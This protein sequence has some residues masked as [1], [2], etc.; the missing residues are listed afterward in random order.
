[1]VV[2]II[3]IGTAV[4]VPRITV[5]VARNKISEAAAL[6]QR[7]L[8]RSFS[9]AARLRKSVTLTA[10]NASA[11]YQV[12]DALAGTVRLSRNLQQ[13]GTL[14]VETMTFS[15][16]V[17]TFLPN[18]IASS[19]ITVTL[20]SHGATRVVTMTRVGLIRRSQ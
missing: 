2:V 13:V 19:P 15:P 4:A 6:V 20:T 9:T 10:D 14:G 7:D 16:T 8:E 11:T 3:G 1:M 18:G 5:L 17:V 12:A